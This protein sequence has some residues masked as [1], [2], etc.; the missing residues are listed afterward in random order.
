MVQAWPRGD[1]LYVPASLDAAIRDAQSI[2]NQITALVAA[3]DVEVV[4]APPVGILRRVICG[5]GFELNGR[6]FNE[7]TFAA[8]IALKVNGVQYWADVTLAP[9]DGSEADHSIWLLPGEALIAALAAAVTTN[10]V[11]CF[12]GWIDEQLSFGSVLRGEIPDLNPVT[13]IPAPP[14]GKTRQVFTGSETAAAGDSSI[15]NP[16]AIAH[17]FTI[18]VNDNGTPRKANEISVGAGSDRRFGDELLTVGE[19]QSVEIVM[20]EAVN[21]TAPRFVSS[22]RENPT[23]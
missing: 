5:T 10:P 11:N 8:A 17:N 16:D 15:Y 3:A 19:N 20:N 13:V 7:D 21:T 6:F 22:Y 23:S 14:A 12:L 9:D 4:P 18:R 2:G 1:Y